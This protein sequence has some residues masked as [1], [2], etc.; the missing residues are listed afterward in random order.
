MQPPEGAAVGDRVVA[1]GFPGE[2]DDVLNPKKKVPTLF[3]SFL[4]LMQVC[5]SSFLGNGID[6]QHQQKHAT[7]RHR[8]SRQSSQT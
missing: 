8:C 2:P 3:T 5:S 4:K 1:E 7:H 6:R